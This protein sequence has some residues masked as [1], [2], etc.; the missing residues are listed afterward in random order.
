[1]KNSDQLLVFWK[2]RPFKRAL[3]VVPIYSHAGPYVNRIKRNKR[4]HLVSLSSPHSARGYRAQK[5]FIYE[6]CRFDP[7][8]REMMA[9][10][11][12]PCMA[13]DGEDVEWFSDFEEILAQ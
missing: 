2:R 3:V 12:L 13:Q 6:S 11:I 7:R 1:M 10:T 9:T 8:F 4:F 5:V